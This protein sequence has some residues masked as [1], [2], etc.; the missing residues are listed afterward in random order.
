MFK[1]VRPLLH[2]ELRL[3]VMSLLVSVEEADFVYLREQT[4]AGRQPERADR[5]TF[6]GRDMSRWIKASW[7]NDRV[8]RAG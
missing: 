4:G 8:P 7:A 1:T 5:E 2:S 3:A 6:K